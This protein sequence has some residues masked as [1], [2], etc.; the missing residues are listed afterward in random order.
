MCL[1]P[2]RKV[3]RKVV[4]NNDDGEGMG[5]DAGVTLLCSAP[6]APTGENVGSPK[7]WG[8]GEPISDPLSGVP[9][10]C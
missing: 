5:K 3:R 9:V 1:P 4:A 6:P 10:G 8:N 7:G 2:E